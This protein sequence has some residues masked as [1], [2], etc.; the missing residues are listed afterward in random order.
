MGWL[1]FIAGA[2]VSGVIVTTTFCLILSNKCREYEM[3]ETNKD[4]I[5]WSVY[6]Y[7]QKCY[8]PINDGELYVKT[9]NKNY[10]LK[11]GSKLFKENN[12]RI[13]GE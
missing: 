4:G 11:C 5:H 7:C 13:A 12:I 2:F 1:S 6:D 8:E 9:H 3:H 10:C